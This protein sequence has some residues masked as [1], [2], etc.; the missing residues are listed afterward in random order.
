MVV[1]VR[2][3]VFGRHG[4]T[5]VE[6]VIALAILAILTALAVPNLGKWIQHYRIRGS[7]REVVSQMELCKIRALK[8]NLEYRVSFDVRKGTFQRQRGNRPD[9]S[10]SWTL[11]GRESVMPKQ[12]FVVEVTFDHE[13]AEFNPDGTATGGRVILAT[14]SGERYR[15]SVNTTTGRINTI[16]MD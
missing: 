13:A 7:V 8:S 1:K 9:S 15:I 11:E 12:V 5:V 3:G 10:S 16:R 14:R 6:F 4:L 2:V